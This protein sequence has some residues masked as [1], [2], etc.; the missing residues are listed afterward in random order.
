[1]LNRFAIHPVV[2]VVSARKRAARATFPAA[3]L[4]GACNSLIFH[5]CRFTPVDAI[6]D[7]VN[8]PG[9]LDSELARHLGR[10]PTTASYV[11]IKN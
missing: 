7:V 4:G 8:R 1:M 10:M 5:F 3:P 2:I 6:H 11:N 9:I